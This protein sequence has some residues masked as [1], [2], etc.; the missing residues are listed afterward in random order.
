[1]GN[2]SHRIVARVGKRLRGTFSHRLMFLHIPKCGGTSIASAIGACYGYRAIDPSQFYLDASAVLETAGQF[3]QHFQQVSERLLLYTM[4]QKQSRYITGHFFFSEKASSRYGDQ[5]QII[6][7]LRDPV[8]R[9]FSQYF[10]N[11]YKKADHFKT[12]ADLESY[13]ESAEGIGAAHTLMNVLEGS[14]QDWGHDPQEGV[15]RAIANLDK[16]ALVGFLEHLEQFKSRFK[17]RYGATL[18]IGTLRKNPASPIQSKTQVPGEIIKQVRHICRY[19]NQIYQY[20][21]SRFA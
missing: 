17:A 6:T 15:N 10:F 18:K 11:R 5:W 20:A 8:S 4:A 14:G 19:D 21:L 13:I 12:D 1:M 9:W 3:D 2:L 7:I 16:I